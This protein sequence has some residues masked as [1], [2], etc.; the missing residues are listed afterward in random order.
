M[1]NTN[2]VDNIKKNYWLS[3]TPIIFILDNNFRQLSLDSRYKLGINSDISR[4]PNRKPA[5]ITRVKPKQKRIK[6]MTVCIAAMF[7]GN[8]II[9]AAD[10]MIS[11][12]G[13][14]IKYEPQQSKIFRITRNDIDTITLMTAGDMALQSEILYNLNKKFSKIKKRLNIHEVIDAYCNFYRTI[15]FRQLESAVLVPQCLTLKSY[16]EKQKK[17][18][19]SDTLVNHIVAQFDNFKRETEVETII[20]GIDDEGTHIYVIKNDEVSCETNNGYAAIGLG[21]WH[22]ESQFMFAKY[23]A[24]W[25]VTDALFLAY[26]AKKRAEVA[27]GIGE[28]TDMVIIFP[29]NADDT[30]ITVPRNKL[31]EFRKAYE[32]LEAISAA[33]EQ[34]VRDAL[35]QSYEKASK[36]VKDRETEEAVEKFNNIKKNYAARTEN[37]ADSKPDDKGNV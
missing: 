7:H 34:K 18:E 8:C 27:E 22:A 30:F 25:S 17:G 3:T 23:T 14:L 33:N 20:S 6:S 16:F 37:K 35:K 10:R 36:A 11:S 1:I 21:G 31:I 15:Y 32:D 24:E 26:K 9:N 13:S 2:A 29:V 28:A 4:R 12:G 5:R 19:L